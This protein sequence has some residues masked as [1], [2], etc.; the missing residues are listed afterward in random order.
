MW[1]RIAV[2]AT[3]QSTRDELMKELWQPVKGYEGLYEV[4]D[5][6]RVRRATTKR[7]L[8]PRIQ[9]G[10]SIFTLYKNSK[11]F[12]TGVHRLVALAF[13]PN[14]L[15][16]E[17]VDHIDNDPANNHVSNLQWMTR[18][19]NQNKNQIGEGHPHSKLTVEQVRAIKKDTRPTAAI[20]AAY[21]VARQTVR[22]ILAGRTWIAV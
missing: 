14:P 12:G 9:S 15:E 21:G 6:G 8:K 20:G 18:K 4:S 5:Q 22:D 19:D 3:D 17:T 7:L 1:Q 10:Y 11:R 16:L 2:P 13:I